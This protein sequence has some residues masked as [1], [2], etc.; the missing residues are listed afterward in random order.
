MK[1]VDEPMSD[2]CG[3]HVTTLRPEVEMLRAQ[4][5]AAAAHAHYVMTSHAAQ[6]AMQFHAAQTNQRHRLFNGELHR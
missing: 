5:Q 6:H 2:G 1:N 4:S 3:S